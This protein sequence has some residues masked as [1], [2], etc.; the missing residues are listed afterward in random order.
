MGGL[1][2]WAAA[3]GLIIC[4]FQARCARLVVPYYAVAAIGLAGSVPLAGIGIT[5][6]SMPIFAQTK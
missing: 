1:E 2:A 4:A 3:P 6:E 5:G